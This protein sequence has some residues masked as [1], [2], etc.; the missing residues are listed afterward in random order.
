[1]LSSFHEVCFLL[2]IN[3]P[4]R[5]ESCPHFG[6]GGVQ[7]S[8]PS[9]FDYIPVALG[10]SHLSSFSADSTHLLRLLPGGN[11]VTRCP[12]YGRGYLA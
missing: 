4:G 12:V 2:S 10:K 5:Y 7:R 1:M 11:E 6:D 9:Q 3:L 8:Q